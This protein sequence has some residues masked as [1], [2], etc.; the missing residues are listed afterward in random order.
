[1]STGQFTRGTRVSTVLARKLG[2]ELLRLRD[3]AGLTQP[4]AAEALSATAATSSTSARTWS[5][6]CG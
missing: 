5:A 2:G 1:V 4:Q 3:R 6:G